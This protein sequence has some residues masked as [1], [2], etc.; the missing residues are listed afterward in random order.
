[1]PERFLKFLSGIRIKHLP[2]RSPFLEEQVRRE[3]FFAS[4]D[5]GWVQSDFQLSLQGLYRAKGTPT[6]PAIAFKSSYTL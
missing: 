6:S 5:L 4:K 3:Y 1:M 2:P